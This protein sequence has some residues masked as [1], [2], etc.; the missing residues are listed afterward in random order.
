MVVRTHTSPEI[1]PGAIA[2]YHS[3][4]RRRVA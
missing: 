1:V 4:E 2:A 3:T